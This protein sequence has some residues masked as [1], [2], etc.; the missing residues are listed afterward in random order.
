MAEITAKMVADLR[1]ATGLGMMECKKALVEAEG[2]MEKAEEILRIKSGAKAGKLAGRTAAE[3]VLAFA[4]EGNTGALVEVNCETDFVA[5]DAG[6]VAFANSVAQTAAAK[7]PATLEELGALVEEERKAIIAKLGENMSVRRFEV[8]ET[9]NSLTAYIHGALATEGVLVEYKGAEDIARK[10]GMHIVAAKPQCVSEA[11]VDAETVEKERHIYT[12][13]AIES[14][15]PADIAAKMVEGRI[16]KFLAEIT[17]NGQAFVMNPDQTVARYLKE[18]GTEVVR[19]VRYKVG[20]GIEKKEVDYAAEVAAA[21][22][23]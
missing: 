18:N 4:I 14:G 3:G 12:Q 7:K 20:D 16:K 2:N 13:Q 8:I 21:A 11:E 5:K 22:K 6:F 15:K 1:A 23:V 19:F 10:V 17:L 9:A